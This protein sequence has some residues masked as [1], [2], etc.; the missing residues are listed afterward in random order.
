[1]VQTAFRRTGTNEPCRERRECDLTSLDGEQDHGDA[2]NYARYYR[3]KTGMRTPEELG[4]IRRFYTEFEEWLVTVR[5][6]P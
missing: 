2:G 6:Q 1:V 4:R 5:E 3:E